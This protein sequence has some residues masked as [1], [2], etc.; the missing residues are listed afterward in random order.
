MV[1]A[2]L[3]D[4]DDCKLKRSAFIDSVNNLVDNY[5]RLQ[6]DILLQL[7]NTYCCSFYGS[8][9][10]NIKSDGYK[11]CCVPLNTSIRKLLCL[12][13]QSILGYLVQYLV[14]TTLVYNW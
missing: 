1:N 4:D 6:R 5:G 11:Y 3:S 7:V 10:W 8:P 13:Y 2:T 12:P 9:L 14:N